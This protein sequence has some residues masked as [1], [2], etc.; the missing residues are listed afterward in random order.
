MKKLMYVMLC[1]GLGLVLCG[2]AQANSLLNPSFD[3]VEGGGGG[4][5]AANWTETLVP[6]NNDGSATGVEQWA[7]RFGY[8]DWGMAVYWWNNGGN[9]GFYQDVAVSAGTSYDY[10]IWATRDAGV[11]AGSIA[12]TIEWYQGLTYLSATSLDITNLIGVEAWPLTNYVNV[13]LTGEAPLLADTA[14]AMISA[15]GVTK[16]LKFDDASFVPEPATMTIL[17]LGSLF[18]ARRRK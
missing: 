10:T 12:M 2:T 11:L 3:P 8:P 9:G 4:G 15:T 16:A 13:S 14:R 7:G 18:L 17:A 6:P 5:A 1:V